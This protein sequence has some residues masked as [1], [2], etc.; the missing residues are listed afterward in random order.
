MSQELISKFT[1]DLWLM[2]FLLQFTLIFVLILRF[3]SYVVEV[4]VVSLKYTKS[5]RWQLTILQL[6]GLVRFLPQFFL[7]SRTVSQKKLFLLFSTLLETRFFKNTHFSVGHR[8]KRVHKKKRV[9]QRKIQF[10][11]HK[12][13]SVLRKNQYLFDDT[14]KDK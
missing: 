11:V 5:A 14:E 7:C 1:M 13:S 8:K 12:K 6:A 10:F 3:C 2:I 4:T 9:F